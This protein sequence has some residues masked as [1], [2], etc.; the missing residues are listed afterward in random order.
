MKNL[1]MHQYCI[2][3]TA[4]DGVDYVKFEWSQTLAKAKYKT[5]LELRDEGVL[6][7]DV[8]FFTFVKNVI[9][10]VNKLN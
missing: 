7:E 3:Y 10:K 1:K 8:D 4:V 9:T 2:W 6:H 5:F